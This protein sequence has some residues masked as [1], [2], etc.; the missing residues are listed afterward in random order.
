MTELV[1]MWCMLGLM[2]STIGGLLWFNNWYYTKYWKEVVR[3][4]GF[5]YY[6]HS[7]N[8]KKRS[9]ARETSNRPN[10]DWLNGK[11]DSL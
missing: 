1:V 9:F 3:K 10:V 6:Q 4:E 8:P 2:L 5:I 7:K 11:T